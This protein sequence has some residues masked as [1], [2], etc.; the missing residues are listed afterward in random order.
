[1]NL[2][3]MFNFLVGGVWVL[4]GYSVYTWL[5]MARSQARG[6]ENSVCL[7]HRVP[8]KNNPDILMNVGKLTFLLFVIS[9][10]MTIILIAIHATYGK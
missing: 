9:I 8:T 2:I 5:C 3:V 10:I 1:M 6:W 4:T 7:S